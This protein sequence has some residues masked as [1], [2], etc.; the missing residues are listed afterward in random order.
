MPAARDL[1]C[2]IPAQRHVEDA[3]GSRD[4]GCQFV[5]VVVVQPR[6][7][8]E[9]VAQWPCDH[10]GAR[11]GADQCEARQRQPDGGRS[12]AFPH[13]D[14]DLEVLHGGVQDLLDGT[15]EPVDLVDEENVTFLQFREDGREVPG[16][17]EGRT[18]G[19]MESHT[20]LGGHDARHCCLAEP[21]RTGEENVIGSLT[22]LLCGTEHDVEVL[23]QFPLADEL[24]ECARTET[25]LVVDV[26]VRTRPGVEEL[27]PHVVPPALP[28]HRAAWTPGPRH[29]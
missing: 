23:L 6:D 29:S 18:A 12:R 20:H 10:S 25:D 13:D 26:G 21:G 7:E 19:D 4:D 15:G 8:T 11:G 3:C 16:A 17:F 5:R 22:A 24:V 28:V 27:I 2:G 14:V 9:P 1:C